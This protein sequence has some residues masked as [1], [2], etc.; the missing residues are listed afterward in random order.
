MT[1]QES[2]NDSL[3]EKNLTKIINK[4]NKGTGNIPEIKTYPRRWVMLVL[5]I[6]YAACTAF[7]WIQ[8]SI[9]TNIIMTYYGV[10]ANSVDWTSMTFMLYYV[11]LVFLAS[12][13]TDRAG[14]RW[15]AI[16][17]CCVNCIGA[18]IKVFS[19]ERDRF[20]LTFIGQSFVATTQ[21]VVLPM[22]G[23]LAAHWF[24]ANE[25]STATSL[26]IFG[27]QLGIALGFVLTPIVVRKHENLDDI[28]VDLS[29]LFWGVAIIST[30]ATI[31]VIIFFQEEPKLSPSQ[32]RALQKATRSE[33]KEGFVE[34]MK[35]LFRNKCFLILCNSYGMNI[36]VL[37]A[38]ATLLNQII[39]LHFKNA[40][41]DAGWIGLSIIVTGMFGAV[42]FGVILDKTHKFKA[43]AVIV[44]FLTLCGQICFAVALW[45][46]IKWMVYVAASFLGFF[47]SGYLAL[48]Y[49][50]CAEYTYP[51]AEG[52]STGILNVANNIYGVLLVLIFGKLMDTYGDMAVHIGCCIALL[53][54]LIMTI[55]TK[56]VQRRQDTR[57]AVT[58][59]GV[60]TAECK[61][62]D[63]K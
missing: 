8:Y 19:V 21:V 39:L 33:N 22:P 5:F 55:F 49:D 35:R 17:G 62:S 18:W 43:T 31:L 14:L 24:G 13:L 57:N 44:Y 11:P 48:G 37:N 63:K 34:P 3:V 47:M 9:V 10:S 32:T 7:Q 53:A 58:Y 61:D 1:Y 40:E 42:T 27:S 60:L 52:I 51:E 30:I 4:E 46:G 12:H 54:G 59:K 38:I 41:R 26:G 15:T 23:R 16:L 20:W 36:G 2:A 45:V 56:D 6:F 28:G 25:V 29:K 50:L